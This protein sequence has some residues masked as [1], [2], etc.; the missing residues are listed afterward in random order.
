MVARSAKDIMS[1]RKPSQRALAMKW[2]KAR[3][4]ASWRL[5]KEAEGLVGRNRKEPC[6]GVVEVL[7]GHGRSW[8]VVGG[9]GRREMW[10]LWG[11][12]VVEAVEARR[13]VE[14]GNQEAAAIRR[15]PRSH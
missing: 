15:Q 11:V 10:G 5:W 8:K 4:L 2:K 1:R 7:E 12:G 9:R 14:S 3:E 6:V 13:H